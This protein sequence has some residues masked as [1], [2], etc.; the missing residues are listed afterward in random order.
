M[1]RTIPNAAYH[2]LPGAGHLTNL[3]AAEAFNRLVV[4]FLDAHVARFS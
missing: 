4:E 2:V 1:G 3:E